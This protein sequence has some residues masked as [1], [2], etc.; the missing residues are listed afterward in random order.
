MFHT[1]F[2]RKSGPVL[3]LGGDY[4]DQA[5]GAAGQAGEERRGG[6]RADGGVSGRRQET[7]PLGSRLY[8]F[9]S[10]QGTTFPLFSYNEIL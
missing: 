1:Q 5:A 3:L 6:G 8:R 7:G 4:R 10:Q 2:P 9:L